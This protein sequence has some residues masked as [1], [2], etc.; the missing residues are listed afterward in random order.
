M[1]V[2][3]RHVIGQKT[4]GSASCY[5]QLHD[6]FILLF[7]K[8]GIWRA[9]LPQRPDAVAAADGFLRKRVGLRTDLLATSEGQG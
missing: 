9:E 4:C 5:W 3:G 1:C 8:I 6:R 7:W 2:T